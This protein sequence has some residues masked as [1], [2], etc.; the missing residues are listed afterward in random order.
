MGLQNTDHAVEIILYRI[1]VLDPLFWSLL[2]SSA[3]RFS[4]GLGPK[5]L[6]DPVYN[7]DVRSHPQ[8]DSLILYYD[9][10]LH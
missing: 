7:R 2:Y 9:G 3:H 6:Q 10:N 1:S 5:V 4:I 8:K